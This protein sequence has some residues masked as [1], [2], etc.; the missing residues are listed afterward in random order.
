MKIKSHLDELVEKRQ[1][2]SDDMDNIV[3][4]EDFDPE[5]EE[6]RSLQANAEKLEKQI[7]AVSKS[8]ELRAAA[9]GLAHR[10]GRATP[11][12]ASDGEDIGAQLIASERFQSWKR[13]GASGRAKLMEIPLR[14][15]LITTAQAPIRPDRVYA[16]APA[17]QATLLS[18]LNRIQVSSGSVEVVTYP[19]A[20]P[21]AGVV[22][23]GT[24]KPEAALAI[25]VSTVNL[26]TI[27]HWIEATRQV[28]EDENRLR[29]FIS[30]SLLRGVTDKA[31]ALGAAVIAGGTGYGLANAPT[32]IEAIRIAIAQVNSAGFRPTGILLNPLDAASLDYEVWSATNGGSGGS[33]SIWGTP[34]I[35]NGAIASGTAYVADFG[36][37]F[38]H[39]FRGTAD[40]FVS[41]SDV[42]LDGISNFK[43]NIITFLAEYRAATA[44]I[45]PEAC[46][47]ATA[48][49]IT[50]NVA[51]TAPLKK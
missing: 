13:A 16:A 33:G 32:M 25:S 23:E 40:L 49:A 27:A 47:K 38:H 51:V 37:A 46:S 2:L 18:V 3:Q 26:Q 19:S 8:I 15:A 9:D 5:G 11:V 50:S 21:L 12:A 14:R 28:I 6:F 20:D 34:V 1:Q 35:P 30:N 48:G 29:D 10:M 17:Q 22:P 31:E 42:G 45:R 7:A 43:R 41:D 39:Y 24:E 44:V 4:N 36:V